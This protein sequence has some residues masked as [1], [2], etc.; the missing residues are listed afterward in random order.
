VIARSESNDIVRRYGCVRPVLTP[1]PSFDKSGNGRSGSVAARATL[2]GDRAATKV[3]VLTGRSDSDTFFPLTTRETKVATSLDVPTSPQP[4][5]HALAVL[6]VILAEPHSQCRP[7]E[8]R[9]A[10]IP[11]AMRSGRGRAVCGKWVT[12][13]P[14]C[15]NHRDDRQRAVLTS[16][17]RPETRSSSGAK[18]RFRAVVRR[19]SMQIVAATLP[20]APSDD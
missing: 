14:K 3:S 6:I 4:T 17:E 15:G 18:R 16:R 2:S 7:E 9:S 19:A 8:A 20:S 10:F 11:K 13:V 12:G 5:A 1:T